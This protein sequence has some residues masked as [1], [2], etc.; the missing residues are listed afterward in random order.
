MEDAVLVGGAIDETEV[1]LAIY[2]GDQDPDII[3]ETLGIEPTKVQRKGEVRGPRSPPYKMSAWFFTLATSA[4][5]SLE[6]LLRIMLGRL[7]GSRARWDEI[8][9]LHVVKV[10]VLMRIFEWTRGFD[11]PSDLLSELA[12]T[13]VDLTFSVYCECEPQGAD[14]AGAD[15]T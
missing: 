6:Q 9:D 5:H 2:C 8:T 3:T 10:N 15:L 14:V 11:L 1:T 4:P 7:S 12:A 13:R